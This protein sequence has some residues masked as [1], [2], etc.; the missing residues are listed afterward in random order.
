[1][2]KAKVLRALCKVSKVAIVVGLSL[3]IDPLLGQVTS[4][5]EQNRILPQFPQIPSPLVPQK[6]P[7][8]IQPLPLQ[9]GQPEFSN[10]HQTIKVK[11]FVL[12]GNTVFTTDHL[13]KV[14]APY[15]GR[16]LTVSELTEVCAALT[17]LYVERG[18]ITSGAFFP[19]EE[20]Q[21]VQASDG[22][23]SVQIVEGKADIKISGAPRLHPYIEARLKKATSPLNQNRLLEALQLLQTDPLIERISAELKELK[24]QPN[25]TV[26]EIKVKERQTLKAEID[27]NNSRSPAVGTFERGI[28]LSDIN[29]LGQR[30]RLSF[31]YKNT[32]GSNSE[33]VSYSI[34][35]N[36]QNGTVNLSY[37]NVSSHVVERPFSKLDILSNARVYELGFRQPLVQQISAKSSEELALGL[38]LSRQESES[39][40]FNTPFP[41]SIGADRK[42]HTR[43]SALSFYQEWLH[44]GEHEV[45]LAKSQFSFGLGAFDA[46]SQF[47]VWR[48]QAGWLHPLIGKTS[49]LLRTDLQLA[50]RP[51]SALEQFGLGGASTVRGYRQDNFLTDNGFLFSAEIHIPIWQEKAGELQLI[52]FFDVGTTWN[53]SQKLTGTFVLQSGTLASLGLGLQFQLG[54]HLS[55]RLD[56]GIPLTSSK[57]NSNATTWQENGIYLNLRYQ[58]W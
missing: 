42:G 27:L 10:S 44:R 18:Y 28:Q 20:N 14:V 23:V 34:P 4:E 37:L 13:E 3:K 16:E 2:P 5:R 52:P 12:K 49:I 11:K 50:D 31:E 22:V 47:F 35:L 9:E 19:V 6:E 36:F 24:A 53:N 15:V 1:M 58:P 55:A 33:H 43:I 56:F 17:K 7:T 48:G 54:D 38:T 51:V 25:A 46:T 45:V 57:N 21:T 32:D 26:L 8:L 29:L 41:L 39:S 40:L 30:D